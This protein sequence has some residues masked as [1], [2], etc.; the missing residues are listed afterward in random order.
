MTAR[1]L[2]NSNPQL[3]NGSNE[4][5]FRRLS[6]PSNSESSIKATFYYIKR[7]MV[8][9]QQRLDSKGNIT[10]YTEKL[11]SEKLLLPPE[12]L[13]ISRVSTNEATGQQWVIHTKESQNRALFALN[14]QII[15]DTISSLNLTP[16]ITPLITP[17][18]KYLKVNISDVHVGMQI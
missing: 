6:N 18:N 2:I 12:H 11:Q 8:V 13:E 15:K 17:S 16:S 5:Y 9:T 14:E 3:E 1:E 7:K 10:S 4:A